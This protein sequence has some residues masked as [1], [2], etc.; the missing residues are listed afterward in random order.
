[1]APQLDTLDASST[2]VRTLPWVDP[3]EYALNLV[4]LI[5]TRYSWIV[6]IAVGLFGNVMSIII[7]LQKDNRKISTC[8]YMT[9][10]AMAD[11][12]VLHIEIAWGSYFHVWD[13][14]PPTEFELQL[15]WYLAY[16][17]AVM[18]GFFLAEMTIDRLIVVRFPLAAPRLCT[19]RRACISIAITFVLISGLSSYIMFKFKYFYNEETGTGV[20]RMSDKNQDLVVLGN[21]TQMAI[22]TILPFVIIVFC[23]LWIFKVLRNASKISR[24]MGVS[25]EGQISREKE[26]AHLNK[27]LILVSIAYVITSIP[28]RAYEIAM[29]IQVVKDSYE[30][31]EAYWGLRIQCVHFIFANIWYMNFG[32]NFYLYCIGGGKKYRDDVRQRLGRLFFCCRKD[33]K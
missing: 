29:G 18:S 25:K 20:L 27:M 11:T 28:F 3:E 21:S 1:M 12:V 8:N 16:A 23:N 33:E 7:T 19:T 24:Q 13:T 5:T 2:A 14:D 6:I 4:F 15:L 10:L 22:G 30:R 9:A 17:F 31:N 32:I 26:T